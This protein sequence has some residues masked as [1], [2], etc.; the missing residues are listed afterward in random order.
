MDTVRQRLGVIADQQ[1]GLAVFDQTRRS[2]LG[3]RHHR[4]TAGLSLEQDLTERVGAAGE[5]EDIGARVG[6]RKVGSVLPAEE[7]RVITQPGAKYLLLRA[8]ARQ[9][10]MQ[11][12]VAGA[13]KLERLCES[14]QP[15]LL[16]QPAD[17]Q[18][19]DLTG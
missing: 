4:Q 8:A 9:H 10:Q 18:H 13:G 16:R 2:A 3:D 15:L 11:A 19:V 6:T 1:A 7:G 5:Q 17:V 14:L 12:L